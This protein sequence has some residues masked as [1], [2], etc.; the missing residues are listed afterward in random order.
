MTTL[1]CGISQRDEMLARL[2]NS[3]FPN[4]KRVH[5][6]GDNPTLVLNNGISFSGYEVL[7]S[8]LS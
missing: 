6:V 3:K 8:L 4:S 2:V 5:R 7:F 1:Y